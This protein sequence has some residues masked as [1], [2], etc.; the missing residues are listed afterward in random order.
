MSGIQV[1][2]QNQARRGGRRSRDKGA[3]S[4]REAVAILQAAGIAAEKIPLSGAAGGSFVG[5]ITTPVLGIDRRLEVKCRAAGFGL[6]Y[7]WLAGHY[8]LVLRADR[9]EP[10]IVLRLKDFAELA[11]RTDQGRCGAG[12]SDD[13]T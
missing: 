7:R 9:S 3:R 8:G 10:L 12:T 4:E 1:I 11:L 13:R 6:I 5:D 2:G